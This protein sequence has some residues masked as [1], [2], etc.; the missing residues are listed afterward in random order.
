MAVAVLAPVLAQAP[1]PLIDAC[2]EAAG[3]PNRGL[4]VRPQDLSAC[5]MALEK[6]APGQM[7]QLQLTATL[8]NRATLLTELGEF[9][10]A[11]ADLNLARQVQPDLASLSLAEGVL[12]L[13]QGNYPA[14]IA[15]FDRVLERTFDAALRATAIYNRALAHYGAGQLDMAQ[16]ELMLLRT[17][18]EA[19]Y[20]TWVRPD[21]MPEVQAMIYG[22]SEG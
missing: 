15:A 14:A 6:P 8:V 13:Y 3:K 17:E 12:E 22:T 19:Q 4:V 2:F 11:R 21:L 9:A 1:N 7:T 20:R 18:H 10:A 5:D 16:I